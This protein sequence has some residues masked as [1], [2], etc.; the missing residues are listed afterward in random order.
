MF[1]G[2]GGSMCVCGRFIY[3]NIINIYYAPV[4]K[5]LIMTLNIECIAWATSHIRIV[6]SSL[7]LAFK[8]HM[9]NSPLLPSEG[10]IESLLHQMSDV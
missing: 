9:Y 4:E 7:Y 8:M 10:D 2:G 3:N 5:P 6:P 1:G